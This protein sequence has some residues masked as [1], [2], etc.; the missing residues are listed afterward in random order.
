M[1]FIQKIQRLN[2]PQKAFDLS[3]SQTLIRYSFIRKRYRY[4]SN[5]GAF[6][7]LRYY[8]HSDIYSCIQYQAQNRMGK[9][10]YRRGFLISN[11]TFIYFPLEIRDYFF[12]MLVLQCVLNTLDGQYIYLVLGR[13][14]VR[15]RRLAD[16]E[17]YNLLTYKKQDT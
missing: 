13:L 3:H 17:Y 7:T 5:S 14:S 12:T 11:F 15:F 1:Y 4:Q 9:S 8:Y 10:I 2:A 16:S 6:M